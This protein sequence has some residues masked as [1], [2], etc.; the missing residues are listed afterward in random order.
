[1]MNSPRAGRNQPVLH[2]LDVCTA[3]GL[4]MAA[5][6]SGMLS[7]LISPFVIPILPV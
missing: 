7:K 5:M 6:A 2:T 3:L 4:Q 1:M